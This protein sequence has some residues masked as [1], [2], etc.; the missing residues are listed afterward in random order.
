[1]KKRNIRKIQ[2]PIV[3]SVVKGVNGLLHL[4]ADM[5]KRGVSEE[6]H[7]G[8]LKGKT[9]DG[10]DIK[11]KYGYGIKVG[12]DDLVKKLSTKGGSAS[13]GKERKKVESWH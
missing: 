2:Y 12:L 7:H 4:V 1:M 13:G 5:N 10:K 6:V 11:V 9:K 8:E 3:K